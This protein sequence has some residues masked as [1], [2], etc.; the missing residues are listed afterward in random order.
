MRDK[1]IEDLKDYK[2]GFSTDIE[3]FKAPKGLNEE[4][5]R[6][7]SSIKKEPDWLL[8]WRLKAFERLKECLLAEESLKKMGINPTIIDARFAKP[9]DE[10]L[11]WQVAINHEVLITL[12][13]G[14]IGGFGAHV[15]HFL[16]EKN[17]LDSNLKF[18][19]MILPD[20]FLD[21]DKPEEMYKEAG[22][23]AKS[24]EAKV[25]ETLN[26]KVVIKKTN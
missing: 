11:M 24:I 15:N 21:Q 7:I 6:F 23:D 22:L 2:Y 26:S 18:R 1:Q 9:L 17:L 25:L 10:N 12:E 14:S 3:S 19:S 5:I 4:V 20:K 16:N 13:E 8:Q